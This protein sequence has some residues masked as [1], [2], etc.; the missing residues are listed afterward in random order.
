MEREGE[1]PVD[2]RPGDRV[3]I[4]D[5]T[6][7]M[8]AGSEGIV[9]GWYAISGEVLIVSFWDGGAIRVPGSNLVR[10]EQ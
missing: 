8:P 4:T 1:R 5:D 2:F 3:R 7:G 10:Q 6:H 9:L